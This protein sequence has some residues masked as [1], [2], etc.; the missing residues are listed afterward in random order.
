MKVFKHF[1]IVPRL[2]RMFNTLAMLELMLWHSKNSSPDGLVRFPF[3]SN[4]WEHVHGKYPTFVT[5]PRNVH[6]TLSTN[7]VNPFKFT[8]SIW[9]TWLVM[10]LNYNIPLWLITKRFLL[11]WHC[12]FP[13]WRILSH[14]KTLMFICNLW[15]KNFNSYGMEFLHMMCSNLWAL[16][17]L[18]WEVPCFGP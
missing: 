5:N 3:D 7:G 6:L 14:Q 4:A 10:L 1:Q 15:L 18:H 8:R 9:S 12:W 13:G 11:C 2:Q 16:G 17:L